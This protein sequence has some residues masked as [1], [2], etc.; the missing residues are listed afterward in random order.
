M[1]AP[2]DIKRSKA[3]GSTNKVVRTFN[4]ELSWLAFN[5]RVL[6]EAA[7]AARGDT[8]QEAVPCHS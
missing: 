5:R 7:R 8:H 3:H 2:T 6:E 4:R 1:N